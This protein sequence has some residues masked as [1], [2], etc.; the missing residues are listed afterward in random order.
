[1]PSVTTVATVVRGQYKL[2]KI[3]KE[4]VDIAKKEVLSIMKRNTL[5]ELELV[6]NV[7]DNRFEDF[8]Q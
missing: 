6:K 7:F 2:D 5:A 4:T 3:L 8:K 1:M